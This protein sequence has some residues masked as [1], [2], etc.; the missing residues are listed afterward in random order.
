[1]TKE[2]ILKK[3]SKKENNDV[4]VKIMNKIKSFAL[5]SLAVASL[6]LILATICKYNSNYRDI[7]YKKIYL[8]NFSF[9][10]VKQFYSKYLGGVSFL[11]KYVLDTKPVFNENLTYYEKSKYYDGVKLKVD[12][13]YLIP[14]IES[15]IVVFKGEKEHYGNVVIIQGMDGVDIWYGNI[16]TSNIN[17]YDY[18][19]EGSFIGETIDETLYLVYSK[20]GNIL[21]YEEY[22]N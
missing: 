16:S 4:K 20:G 10:Q 9:T 3:Y 14:S 7:I 17:L 8:D 1:M 11:D 6:F 13:N 22:L 12:S 21:N 19:E 5:R 18:I 2:E 15:G